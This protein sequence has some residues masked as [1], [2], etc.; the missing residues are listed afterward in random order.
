MRVVP[1]FIL[2]LLS[3]PAASQNIAT[4]ADEAPDAVTAA[5]PVDVTSET[6]DDFMWLNRL[7]V[8]FADTPRDPAFVRQLDLVQARAEALAE[9]DVVV[10]IDTDP[11]AGTA[12][13]TALRPH[14]FAVVIV[15][16]DGRVL[17]RKPTPWDVREISAAIDKTPLRQQELKEARELE[18]IRRGFPR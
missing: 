6:L 2:L 17:Q 13:R 11:A 4:V 10:L 3:L 5:Q 1:A 18:A 8:I 7:V 14:G 12:M 15:D 16:K 9:R